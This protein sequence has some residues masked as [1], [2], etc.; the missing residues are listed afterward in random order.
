M[1]KR[2]WKPKEKSRLDNIE[3]HATFGTTHRTMTNRTK[4]TT[5]KTKKT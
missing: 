2:M 1:N 3:T 5:Q 4:T